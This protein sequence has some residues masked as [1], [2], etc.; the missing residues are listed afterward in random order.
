ML[1]YTE[2]SCHLKTK[3]VRVFTRFGIVELDGKC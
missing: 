2:I 3:T 1:S